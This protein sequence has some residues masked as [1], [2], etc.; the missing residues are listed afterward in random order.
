MAEA[1]FFQWDDVAGE[2]GGGAVRRLI[3]GEGA[4]LKRVEIPAGTVAGRHSHPHEQFVL[5]LSGTGLLSCGAGEVALRPGTVIRF[6]RD[7]W[8]TARFDTATVLVEVNLA[9]G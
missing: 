7:A 5:V 4:S 2:E 9:E 8:H 3:P 1:E 6:P